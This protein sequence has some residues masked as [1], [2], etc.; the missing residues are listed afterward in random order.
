MK[1]RIF[2]LI[3]AA[4]FVLSALTAFAS[5]SESKTNAEDEP[6]PTQTT[7]LTAPSAEADV[8]VD[9][10]TAELL[11]DIPPLDFGGADFVVCTSGPNDDNGS[12]WITYDVYVEELNG[13]VINDAV[14]ER[15]LYLNETYN[16]NFRAEV[17][18]GNVHGSI[19]T[20]VKA[21]G[22]TYDAGFTGI[23]RGQTL[24]AQG[25][26]HNMFTVPYVD[27]SKPWWDHRLTEDCTLLG[28]V[29]LATGDITVIDN[30]ATW[31][32]MFNKQMVIDL[33]LEDIYT[34]VREDR[35][36]YDTLYEMLQTA[37][38]DTDGNGKLT[39]QVDT[40]GLVT[41]ANTCYG[42]LYASGEQLAPKDADGIPTL[43]ENIDRIT[44]VVEKAG[45]ILGNLDHVFV[46]DRTG[47]STDNLRHIFEEGRSLFYGEVAQCIIRMRNSETDF[48]VIPWPKFDDTQK[49]F[50]NFV[51]NTAAKAIVIPVTE[52]DM[53]MCG[54]IVEAMAAKSKYTLTPAYYD[55]AL[56][57][58]Y[59]RDEESSEMMDIILESRCYDPAYIND[60]G[61]F[62]GQIHSVIYNGGTNLASKWSST[63]K[64]FNKMRDKAIDKL[65]EI[66]A[67]RGG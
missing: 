22:G 13:E 58:K 21:G 65:A 63:S 35:W 32:L 66:Q 50:Y 45:E 36:Y 40:Y 33:G 37:T 7:D 15:N 5:C 8:P 27:L 56:T 39:P 31:I 52:A 49:G 24:G 61:S 1:K 54:A 47:Y 42:L 2:S 10:E 30:D 19:Q 46:C 67:E 41:T 4:L 57:Y 14:F 34:L 60:W 55:T 48:G 59:M 16:I 3:L 51:H 38:R 64:A 11:P 44:S 53:E 23:M 12:D 20:D 43:V 28:D 62:A 29:Y 6:A 25:I 18:N 9:D 26:T 17:T